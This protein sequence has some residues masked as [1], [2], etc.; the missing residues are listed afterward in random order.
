MKRYKATK[1]TTENGKFDSM[2]EAARFAQLKLYERMGL[3][4]DLKKQ[5]AFKLSVNKGHMRYTAD[6]CYKPKGSSLYVLEDY[7]PRGWNR[8]QLFQRFIMRNIFGVEV[9]LTTMAN[10]GIP[11]Q[12]SALN[13]AINSLL[14]AGSIWL[15]MSGAPDDTQF[16]TTL[17]NL[18][19]KKD[20]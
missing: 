15:K 19:G 3:L 2:G 6:F 11:D 1:A 17:T 5:V 9:Y 8:E 13:G 7:K 18:P 12:A 14:D 10:A 4:T 20:Q 16:E